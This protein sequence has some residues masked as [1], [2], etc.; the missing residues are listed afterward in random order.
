MESIQFLLTFS[1][2]NIKTT[3]AIS[4]SEFTPTCKKYN[5]ARGDY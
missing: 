1:Q 5:M 3:A 2:K 4:P